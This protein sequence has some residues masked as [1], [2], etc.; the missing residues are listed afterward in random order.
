MIRSMVVILVPLLVITALFTRN[1]DD[2]PVTEV[3]WRPVLATAR[4]E[5][6]YPVVA[7]SNLPEGWR[8]TRVTWVQTGENHLGSPSARNYW[9]LGFLAPDDV[10]VEVK[11]GDL[12]A[13]DF[14]E[15]ATQEGRP[16]GTSTVGGRAWERRVSANDRTR[17]LVLR[18]PQVAT[19][20]AGDTSYGALELFASTLSAR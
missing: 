9:Q 10:Y 14:I 3:E 8:P 5:A 11:Q 15:D 6:P 7:P 13:E 18:S 16:D 4:K 1:L 12:R 19:V 17:S 20:V 2:V